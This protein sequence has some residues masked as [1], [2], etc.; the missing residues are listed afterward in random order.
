MAEFNISLQKTLAHEGG[1]SNDPDDAG[2][3]T[4]KGISRT[5]HKNW[6][7]WILIDKYKKQSGFPA[8]LDKD[9][10]LAKQVEQFYQ[11]NFWIPLNADRINNQT[12]ADS[13]FDFAVNAG[14][15]TSIHL[16]QSI[17]EADIDGIIGTQTLDKLNTSNPTH[18][19]TDFTLAK[20]AHYISVIKK[21]PTN[22]K[23]LYGWIIR[24]LSFHD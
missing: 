14:I 20:I 3:K 8:S 4:Y 12:V 13:I 17:V 9:S 19:L 2:G 22:K 11:A 18:F 6:Y 10:E 15:Q 23:Y 1:Y 7:G 21:R 16:V 24:A 5:N